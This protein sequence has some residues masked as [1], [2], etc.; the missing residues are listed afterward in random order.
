MAADGEKKAHK[1]KKTKSSQVDADADD[2]EE[3]T[4]EKKSHH[5]KSSAEM[6]MYK[7]RVEELEAKV[8]ELSKVK[9]K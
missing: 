4:E 9:N 3:P 5:K 7:K 6:D 1:K 8:E 2:A